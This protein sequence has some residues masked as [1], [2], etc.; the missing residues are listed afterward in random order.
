MTVLVTGGAGFIGSNLVD[1]LL[2]EGQKVVVLDNLSTGRERN[3]DIAI[4]NGAQLVNGDVSDQRFVDELVADLKPTAIHHLAAQVDVRRSVSNPEQDAQTN[5]FGTLS[6]LEAARNH[7][8]PR[9]VY[10]STGGAI[11]GEADSYPTAEGA[12]VRPMSPYG[13]NKYAAELHW[14]LYA[15]LHGLSTITL[16]LANVYGPRQDPLGEGG[17]VAIFCRELLEGNRALIF[18]DGEQTRDFVEVSDVAAACRLAAASD[19]VGSFNIGSSSETTVN[20]L[21][22]II[23]EA[24]PDR[25]LSTE[26]APERDGEVRR[27]CLDASRASTVLGWKPQIEL[28]D[29]LQRTLLWQV[30]EAAGERRG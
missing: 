4:A 18:G 1:S 19:V 8:V 27:S 14:S 5:L 13:V 26:H 2:A 20:Q 3:L 16:R 7:G 15:R 10:V 24:D 30:E 6:V 28:L 12:E 29:G 17:V 21:A 25:K 23:S 22:A 9:L 11:Y